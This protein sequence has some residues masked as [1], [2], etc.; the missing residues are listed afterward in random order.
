VNQEHDFEPV[1]GLPGNLPHGESL[2]WQ[3]SPVWTTIARQ[4]FYIRAVAV[5]FA[6]LIA[7]QIGYASWAGIGMTEAITAALWIALAGVL[8]IGLLALLARKT[9]Q[10]TIYTIT[11]R[12]VVL[13]YGIALPVCLNLPFATIGAA[14]LGMHDDGTG[15]VSLALTGDANIAYLHL[16]PHARPWHL[17]KTEPTMRALPKPANVANILTSALADIHPAADRKV[18]RPTE[19]PARASHSSSQPTL[20]AV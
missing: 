2:L 14:N 3:G 17:K 6:V 16:W 11:S 8:A 15:D 12:R 5:Y 19:K 20:S 1:P 7:Y 18:V 9:A 4:V 13:R 10:T